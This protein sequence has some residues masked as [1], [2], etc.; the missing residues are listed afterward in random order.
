M[1]FGVAKQ[2]SMF[3]RVPGGALIVVYSLQRMRAPA[4]T[5]RSRSRLPCQHRATPTQHAMLMRLK[6]RGVMHRRTLGLHS[7]AALGPGTALGP[8]NLICARRSLTSAICIGPGAPA[9]FVPAALSFAGRVSLPPGFRRF[10]SSHPLPKPPGRDMF[11]H[12][13]HPLDAAPEAISHVPAT[14]YPS[15]RRLCSGVDMAPRATNL[16]SH[17]L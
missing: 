15:R 5:S 7:L 1:T 3:H 10:L 16:I 6:R 8:P 12:F 13:H 4:P 14:G 11:L 17:L 2:C 9:G